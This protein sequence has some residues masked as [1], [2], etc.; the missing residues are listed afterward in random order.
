MHQDNCF[1]TLT[2]NDENLPPDRSLDHRHWQLFMKKL[3][4]VQ[5]A[6]IKY[7]MCGEYG[8]WCRHCWL[9]PN[10]CSCGE[11]Q[12]LGPGRPHY[13]A[14]LFNTDFSD[15][16]FWK[17]TNK[18]PLYR[19]ALL[20]KT[21][22]KGFCSVG[23]ATFQSAAYVARYVT[24]KVTGTPAATHY[25][26]TNP[27]TG[28]VIQL[29]PEYLQPSRGGRTGKGIASDWIEEFSADVWPDDFVVVEGRKVRPPRFYEKQLADADPDL[30]S[31][32]K[33]QRSLKNRLH[34]E[35]QTPARLVV[36]EKVQQA[37]LNSLKRTLD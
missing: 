22:G 1:V 35:N 28:E 21:W 36:R 26:V 13:H 19:S 37:K 11:H 5:G 33:R 30:H 20:E 2:Y 9:H 18:L 29:R 27:R 25:T 16:V 7:L 17:E 6:G 31:K 34:A 14:I 15:K 24:K 3:R 8:V 32:V 10:N 12:V 4:K 23:A